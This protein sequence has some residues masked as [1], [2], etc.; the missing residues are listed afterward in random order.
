MKKKLSLLMIA[1]VAIAAFAVQ[2]GR[3]A[4]DSVT[5]EVPTETELGAYIAENVAKDVTIAPESGDIAAALTAA[6]EEL[7]YNE[8]L[9]NITINLT[10]G[11]A[12]TVS[13]PI[14]APASL[15]I[16]GNGA[17]IDASG[18]DAA[19]ITT[20]AGDLAEWMTGNLIVKDVTV[21]GLKKSLYASAGK[22]YLYEDFLI[23]NS[24]I[25]FN[26]TS[27]LE[28][29]FRKGGVAKNFTIN[30]STLYA[31]AATGN[32]FYTSQSAQKG[33]EAPGVTIQTFAIT[34]ST[35]YN[36][37]VGKNFFTHRQANQTWLGYTIK[38]SIFLNVGKSGQV[39]KGINQGQ[40]GANPVWDIDGN[41]FN[42]ITDGVITDTSS[43][44][45]TGDANEPV[46]NSIAGV[47]A[48]ANADYATTGNFT[49][50]N[51]AQ[52][53]AHIGDPRWLDATVE[54]EAEDIVIS[55]ESGDINTALFNATTAVNKKAKNITINLAADAA[56]TVSASI[57]A[58]ASL[59]INGNGAT[60]DASGLDAAMITTP[61][62]DLAEWMTGNLIVKDVT[63][64]GLKKSLYASAGKNYLYEDFLIE[65]SVIEFNET[66]GLEFDFRKG[67]VA[68]NFTINKSTLYA[69][70]ATGNSFYTSQSAQ[71][72][73][74]AP[75]VTIQTFAITNSTLYNFAVGKN[76]FTHRQANQ[77]WLGYTI[78]NSIFLNVGKSGQVVKGINQGQSGAN[79]VWDIDGNA[80]NFITDGVITDTSSAED[81][82][83]AN[84][85]VKNSIAGVITFTDA[86]T[87]NF[88]GTFA[89]VEGT[90]EPEALGDPRWTI[91][92]TTT[93]INGIMV[94][95]ADDADAPMYNLSGQRV[96]KSYKGIVIKNG[97]KVVIK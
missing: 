30:K 10:A 15:T 94:E 73:T 26:E 57:V 21:K 4:A 17:T 27:G 74:E 78:K 60:I 43:A 89:L 47:V 33:T 64:K 44:E 14:V 23:E 9:G 90:T 22:N 77:T 63:V 3:R 97:K 62:G 37:A 32:S 54:P 29:D 35:L 80:F 82:G 92:Y 6:K 66:S 51:C 91:S 7:A 83:D 12:Y 61:A 69:L 2:V 34:N 48:F 71:K 39:V 38:N 45:D 1:L 88:N 79:P 8:V 49:L 46:K 56:Y 72:G 13:A 52:N 76:F 96:D 65:N 59:T 75:G 11:A 84:E 16:N 28:F 24:V 86:A 70:A 42:F 93:G 67:G 81:T 53:T 18:L 40:S 87:G 55:P 50:A 68:K 41:A 31:L 19:M 20:P 36:F 85:P 95:D 58:P 5:L 25:E